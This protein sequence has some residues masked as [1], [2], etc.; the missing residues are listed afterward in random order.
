[1]NKAKIQAA[2]TELMRHH[3]DTNV[4]NPSSVAQGG[5]AL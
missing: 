5:K 4:E 2:K 1:M 3:L